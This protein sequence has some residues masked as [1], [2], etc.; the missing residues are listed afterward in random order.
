[1]EDFQVD[2]YKQDI[3]EIIDLANKL[4]GPIIKYINREMGYGLFA[5]RNYEKGEFVT[6]YG[7]VENDKYHEGDYVVFFHG[8]TIDSEFKFQLSEKGRWINHNSNRIINVEL[9]YKNGKLFFET[10]ENVQRGD[11]FIWFYGKQ[12]KFNTLL[13][14]LE[15]VN[16]TIISLIQ[17]ID[18]KKVLIE[19]DNDKNS[20]KNE[21]EYR[22]A[23]FKFDLF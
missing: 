17:K 10:T 12:Y 18:K 9:K 11:E 8:K 14:R 7:G 19:F 22:T 13:N 23:A 1:M 4:G 2:L 16:Q 20:K 15:S 6:Y 21:K 5:E 3:D